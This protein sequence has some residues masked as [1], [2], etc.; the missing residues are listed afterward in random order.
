M[1][2]SSDQARR[3]GRLGG[4][5]TAARHGGEKMTR[6]ARAALD[7]KF[8]YDVDPDGALDPAERARRADAARRLHMAKLAERR[9]HK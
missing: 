5:T 1:A 9:G 2:L 6:A 8:E 3:Y 7:R 4:L